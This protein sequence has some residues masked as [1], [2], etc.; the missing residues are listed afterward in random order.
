MLPDFVDVKEKLGRVAELW[1]HK[2]IREKAPVLG[3]I[4]HIRQHEGR[5]TTYRS[6]TGRERTVDYQKVIGEIS[7]DPEEMLT[8]TLA[9]AMQRVDAVADQ[10]VSQIVPRM[11][12]ELS[13]AIDEVGNTVDAAGQPLT[14][15]LLLQALEKVEIDFDEETGE[16]HFPTLVMHPKLGERLRSL[17]AE[18]DRNEDYT[19][20]LNELVE[21]KWKAW[22]DRE[23]HRKLVD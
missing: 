11:F 5:Q 16:P 8:W 12:S 17:L 19:R 22:R 6:E 1:L 4:R 10:M 13:A 3:M 20:R 9:E 14:V 18:A 23:G 21:R 2:R 15:D 7:A